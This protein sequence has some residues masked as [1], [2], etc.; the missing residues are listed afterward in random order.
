MDQQSEVE[1][2]E[3]QLVTPTKADKKRPR[4]T[5]EESASELASE[6]ASGASD[7]PQ[8]TP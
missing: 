3:E 8:G 5:G 6:Q 2:V 4:P 7:N 1:R